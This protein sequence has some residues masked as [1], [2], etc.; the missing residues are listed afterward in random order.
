[1]K[2][3]SDSAK[4][5]GFSGLEEH[6]DFMTEDEVNEII[7]GAYTTDGELSMLPAKVIAVAIARVTNQVWNVQIDFRSG[8]SPQERAIALR[9]AQRGL[10]TLLTTEDPTIDGWQWNNDHHFWHAGV[11]RREPTTQRRRPRRQ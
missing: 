2:D 9:K 5:L 7:G 3:H 11:S 4:S 10:F 1:L 8:L 6:L